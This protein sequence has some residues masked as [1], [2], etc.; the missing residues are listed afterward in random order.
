M[1][2]SL[3]GRGTQSLLKIVDLACC[4]TPGVFKRPAFDPQN[5]PVVWG[6]AT[7]FRKGLKGY[8][9]KEGR[10]ENHESGVTGVTPRNA[11][12]CQR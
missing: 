4:K 5:Q 10:G 1:F 7:T 8:L 2:R 9:G 3:V 11:P 12:R 6:F